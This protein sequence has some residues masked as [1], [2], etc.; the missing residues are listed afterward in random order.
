MV[1]EVFILLVGSGDDGDEQYIKGVFATE[2]AAYAAE[3]R[4]NEPGRTDVQTWEV[5]D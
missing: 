2:R 4:I 5:K 3:L 1:Q